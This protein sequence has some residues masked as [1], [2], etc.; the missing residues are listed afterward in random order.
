MH[1]DWSRYRC[2][3]LVL[4]DEVFNAMVVKVRWVSLAVA[5]TSKTP[6]S[7]ERRETLAVAK[8]SKTPP[9]M[10]CHGEADW[11]LLDNVEMGCELGAG[12]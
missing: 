5:K 1:K 11:W 4:S 8:T 7:M 12:T 9:L 3:F 10:V 2:Q 6:S